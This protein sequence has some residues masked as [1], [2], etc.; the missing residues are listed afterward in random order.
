[1]FGVEGVVPVAVEFVARD[2]QGRHLGVT[3]LD[4]GE[5]NGVVEFGVD[6]QTGWGR[7]GSDG[8]D[9]DLVAVQGSA[10]P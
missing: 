7:R 6:F 9:D 5:I 2:G 10:A 1:M 3:D 8:I 4:P